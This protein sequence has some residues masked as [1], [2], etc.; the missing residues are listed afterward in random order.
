MMKLGPQ[1]SSWTGGPDR[2]PKIDAWFEHSHS[3]RGRALETHVCVYSCLCLFNLVD[4]LV[5]EQSR[6]PN[7]SAHIRGAVGICIRLC[8][9]QARPR[10]ECEHSHSDCGQCEHSH[11]DRGRALGSN[12][13]LETSRSFAHGEPSASPT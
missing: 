5:P 11:S 8:A 2:T 6:D 4:G 10:S 12:F 7:V 9:P 1:L 13:K 3:N